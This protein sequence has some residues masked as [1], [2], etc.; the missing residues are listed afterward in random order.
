[1]CYQTQ[2]FSQSNRHNFVF[3][4]SAA[5]PVLVDGPHGCPVDHT[6]FSHILLVAGGIGVFP[7]NSIIR[8]L[9]TLALQGVC[10]C[11]EVTL[12]WSCRNIDHFR[13]LEGTLQMIQ[14]NPL[15]GRFVCNIHQTRRRALTDPI[16]S[17]PKPYFEGRPDLR[18]Y[19]QRLQD[20]GPKALVY[21]CGP[22]QMTDVCELLCVEAGVQFQTLSYS[23][24]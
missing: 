18:E 24:S 17:A 11:E 13:A 14:E 4:F 20:F 3:Y 1:V 2:I 9:Y 23:I 22:P 12:V 5:I 8:A 6:R 7:C 15:N 10:M 21:V 19:V 16:T